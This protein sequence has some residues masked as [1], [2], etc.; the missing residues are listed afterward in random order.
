MRPSALFGFWGVSTIR[1][2]FLQFGQKEVRMSL[3]A[4]IQNEC[5]AKD[6]SVTRL[7]R[8]CLQLAARLKHDPLK[9]WVLHELNGY[10][11]ATSIPSYR[12][13]STRSRGFFY[14]GYRQATLDIPMSVLVDEPI[15]ARFSEAR[16]TQPI[17]QYEELLTEKSD[18]SFQIP[19]PQE[20]ALYYGPKVSTIQCLR[21]WQDLPR[22]AVAG[23]V[24][25]VKTRVLSMVLDIEA[26]NPMAGDI[27]GGTL[28]IPESKVA[29]IFNTNIYGG[30][31][32]NL[33]T[34][35]SGV[36]QNVGDQ[37]LRGDLEGLTKHLISLGI[38][39]TATSDL[40]E[41]IEA[42][43]VSGQTGLGARV[44]DWLGRLCGKAN[45]AGS[46]IATQAVIGAATQA[47][48][49]YFGVSG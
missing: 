21:M 28:P 14:D 20:L 41:A 4:E 39:A 26:E 24:D 11:D 47:I 40:V 9:T 6:G 29:Q 7:L 35:S 19:W 45:E 31:V 27:P 23:L 34:G 22:I 13:C 25:S 1:A 49:A 36:V 30:Q 12:L 33:A 43:R 2:A 48:L 10:P 42:D 18:G 5:I 44:S 17:R 46:D 32:G 3:L 37:I 16:L 15:R 8:L 38:P